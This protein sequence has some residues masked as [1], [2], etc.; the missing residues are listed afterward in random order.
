MVTSLRR[1]SARP[2]QCPHAMGV[3]QRHDANSEDMRLTSSAAIAALAAAAELLLL[4]CCCG[5][6]LWH[7]VLQVWSPA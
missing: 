5:E 3:N 2:R 7:A 1:R 4:C 6:G